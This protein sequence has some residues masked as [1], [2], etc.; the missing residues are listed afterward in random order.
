[1]AA[2]VGVSH[3]QRTAADVVI[4]R[5]VFIVHI[6]G[7]ARDQRRVRRGERAQPVRRVGIKVRLSRG[8]TD[9]QIRIRP[10]AGKVPAVTARVSG[11]HPAFNA[12]RVGAAYVVA[13]SSTSQ[14]DRGCWTY[15][16]GRAFAPT[17]RVGYAGLAYIADAAAA[18]SRSRALRNHNHV[19]R[20]RHIRRR[21]GHVSHDRA[22]HIASHIASSL[23]RVCSRPSVISRRRSIDSR[24]ITGQVPIREWTRP[25][26]AAHQNQKTG[27]QAGFYKSARVGHGA[28]NNH[29]CAKLRMILANEGRRYFV[30]AVFG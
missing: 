10:A 25:T 16:T 15:S 30:G 8:S 12:D 23:A 29:T 3:P 7:D 21:S 2:Q 1:M 14:T 9:K 4:R 28:N 18:T 20:A 22:R 5:H 17:H 27:S 13:A 26:A 19:G 11:R 24:R 6:K